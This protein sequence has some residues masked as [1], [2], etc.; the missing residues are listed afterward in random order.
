MNAAPILDAI[1]IEARTEAGRVSGVTVRAGGVSPAALL[2]RRRDGKDIPA[3]AESIFALCPMAQSTAAACAIAVARGRPPP[4]SRSLEI[5]LVA[6]R[7]AENMRSSLLAWPGRAEPADARDL[8][9]LREALG[10]LQA[11]ARQT[12]GEHCGDMD[13]APLM[14]RL[15]TAARDLG[16]PSSADEPPAAGWFGRMWREAEDDG[17]LCALHAPDEIVETADDDAMFDF[18][19]AGIEAAPPQRL[20]DIDALARL[21]ARWAD[22]SDAI[23]RLGRLAC[24]DQ[25]AG[26]GVRA[27]MTPAGAGVAAVDSPR[28]RL[29]HWVA[30]DRDGHATDYRILSPTDR[31]FRENGAFARALTGAIIGEAADAEL[32]V[33]RLAAL[34]D[35]CVALHVRI[36]GRADA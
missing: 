4:L 17:L 20:R 7:I 15:R 2:F 33:A 34:F 6:E 10:A 26:D 3:L 22:L 13:P 12:R 32:R 14:A 8:A 31:N 25:S 9:S 21:R 27:R 30:L 1:H 24:G 36:E 5:R 18:L 11:L 29:Y 35:P 19:D 28:G 16:L 23:D